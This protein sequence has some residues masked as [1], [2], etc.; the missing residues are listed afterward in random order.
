MEQRLKYLTVI[1][2][3]LII[4]FSSLFAQGSTCPTSVYPQLREMAQQFA[5]DAQMKFSP[6]TGSNASYE[7]KSC[8]V[9][10]LNGRIVAPVTLSWSAQ[11]CMLCFD[12]AS[13]QVY[14]E[15]RATESG[16]V[17]FVQTG[18][19]SHARECLGSHKYNALLTLT[20]SLMN[21]SSN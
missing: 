1:G 11:T 6:N 10:L 7:L 4:P 15:I 2:F 3:F 19:N 18:T 17:Q 16:E 20:N 21:S 14:G 12:R 9:D 13:A 5:N 8:E